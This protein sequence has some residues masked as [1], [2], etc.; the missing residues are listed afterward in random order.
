MSADE[1]ARS[2]VN[3][4]RLALP[5]IIQTLAPRLWAM[6]GPQLTAPSRVVEALASAAGL[7]ARDA[8]RLGYVYACADDVAAASASELARAGCV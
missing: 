4:A 5:Q 6:Y 1:A 8:A 2:I 3:A 7:H